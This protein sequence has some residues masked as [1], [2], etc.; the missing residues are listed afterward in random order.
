MKKIAAVIALA[1]GLTACGGPEEGWVTFMEHQ[2]SYVTTDTVPNYMTTCGY[3][4]ATKSQTCKQTLIGFN[5]VERTVDECYY[6]AFKDDSGE[7]GSDCVE[8]TRFETLKVGD[9]Y[10]VEDF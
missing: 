8:P 5:E 4:P 2:P 3:D 7:T 1:L 10:G 9:W 6:I